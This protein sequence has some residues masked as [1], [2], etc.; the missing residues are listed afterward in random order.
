MITTELLLFAVKSKLCI[1]SD[2]AIIKHL[3]IARSTLSSYRTSG[4]VLG[5]KNARI[6]A[7]TLGIP[8]HVVY[9]AMMHERTTVDYEKAAWLAAYN[10]CNGADYEEE[11]FNIIEKKTLLAA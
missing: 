3:H 2:Y 4:A 10:A 9:C 1:D 5:N 6:I 11:I 7:D 8:L